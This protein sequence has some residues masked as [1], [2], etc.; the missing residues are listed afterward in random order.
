MSVLSEFTGD[1]SHIENNNNL[2]NTSSEEKNNNDGYLEDDR[3]VNRGDNNSLSINSFDGIWPEYCNPNYV[4]PESIEVRVVLPSGDF[5][6]P[7]KIVKST[8]SN[9]KPY[10]GGYR[11]KNNGSIYHHASSQT[12]TENRKIT[13]KDFD[14]LRTRETQTFET[15][16][17]SIQTIRES[18]TQMSRVDLVVDN[19]HDVVKLSRRYLTAEVLHNTKK[20]SC[21]VIQRYWRGY[22]ARCRAHGIR[23][24]NVEYFENKKIEK[25]TL[26]K[27]EKARRDVDMQRRLHPKSGADFEIL[28]N[29]LEDWRKKEI[30]KIKGTTLPGDQRTAALSLLLADE[31]K[32]LQ[33]I[34]SLKLN[35]HRTLTESKTKQMLECMSKPHRWQ[36]STG[37]VAQVHTP[38]TKQARDFLDIYEALAT[39]V[40]GGTSI[41]A[42]LEILLNAKWKVLEFDTGLTRDICDLI[43]READLLNRGRS[44]ASMDKLRKRLLNL[45]LEFLE[46]PDI[47]PR[48]KDFIGLLSSNMK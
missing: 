20:V 1:G 11:N 24:R 38:Q 19:R 17:L 45:F 14:N 13:R 47:N 22:Q 46:D 36:L 5:F 2:L 6:F 42:R 33:S 44:V 43:D 8:D 23:T 21:L 48:A 9:P 7:V 27:V 12:P 29:E 18:G 10:L 26:E 37:D 25:E 15:K 32:A 40:T 28:Y 30:N 34:Q 35:A 41:E 3:N 31:T 39:P 16:T 4:M